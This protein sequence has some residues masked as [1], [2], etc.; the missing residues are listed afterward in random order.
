MANDVFANNMEVS[1][2]AGSGKSICAFPD[3]CM[4]PPEN[5]ATPPGV[6]VP[7]PNTG[8]ASDTTNG[9]STVKISGQEVM[10]K[11]K[12]YFKS[13]TGDEAGC[14]AKKGV[15]TSKNMGKVYFN[16]WSMDVKV[17]GENVVRHLDITTHNHASF[18]GNSPTWPFIDEMAFAGKGPCKGVARD[19]KT[20]CSAAAA[21]F[22][23]D[24]GA[25]GKTLPARKRKAAMK[26]MC[27]KKHE[28]CREALKCVLT[29]KSPNNCCPNS[30]GKKP[31][32]HHIV[33][34][35][36]F[37]D[38]SGNRIKLGRGKKYSYNGA[39]CVC[40]PGNSHSTGMH[41]EIHTETNNL[42]INHKSLKAAN[43]SP[44]G[45]SII[46]EPRWS[47]AEAEEVGA[48]AVAAKSDCKDKDCIKAQVRKG[49]QDMGIEESDQIRPT[50]A[51]EVTKPGKGR[52]IRR[53]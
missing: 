52:T 50:T 14:A 48:T 43:V 36:Q 12:S 5:P 38:S 25:G 15:V 23:K 3:V 13:S 47:V 11:N 44:T 34:D 24:D 8:M 9:S 27:S 37:K 6:P 30:R 26:S 4:T 16:M 31:T 49:H 21:P 20:H 17:E 29:K 45:K 2:K 7:Y 18:P 42:T 10:L 1:C 46:G 35:S 32:P 39:P 51:G 41:G 33:P 19:L 40:A 22:L 53:F 28:K